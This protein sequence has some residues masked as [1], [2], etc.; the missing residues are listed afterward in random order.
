M[1]DRFVDRRVGRYAK[2]QVIGR[3]ARVADEDVGHLEVVALSERGSR[4]F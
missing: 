4:E 2:R 1:V 3:Q